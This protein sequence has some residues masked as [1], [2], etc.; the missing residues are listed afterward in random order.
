MR[1]LLKPELLEEPARSGDVEYYFNTSLKRLDPFYITQR[2]ASVQKFYYHDGDPS[3]WREEYVIGQSTR[4]V[5]VWFRNH[6][7]MR[8]GRFLISCPN[9]LDTYRMTLHEMCEYSVFGQLNRD[10]E[11]C[12]RC[13][14]E[15]GM[16][17]DWRQ[18]L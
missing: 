6:L 3:H 2:C 15:L 1:T 14:D 9:M 13:R 17:D 7:L 11:L 5:G 18:V 4:G 16:V 12:D 10:T 8:S